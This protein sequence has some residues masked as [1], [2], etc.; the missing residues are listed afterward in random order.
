MI[1]KTSILKIVVLA[2]TALVVIAVVVL[3]FYFA[4][5]PIKE[6][7]HDEHVSNSVPILDRI[8]T[9]PDPTDSKNSDENEQN[10]L[11][12][13]PK[14]Y[15]QI[16][17]IIDNPLRPYVE[18]KV[19]T[20][21]QTFRMLLD[22]GWRYFWVNAAPN[23]VG[24][25]FS[26]FFDKSKSST[27][28]DD[29]IINDGAH[30]VDGFCGKET[31]QLG[32]TVVNNM[33]I[34]FGEEFSATRFPRF[35]GFDGIIG[36]TPGSVFLSEIATLLPSITEKAFCFVPNVYKKVGYHF[37]FDFVVGN[38]GSDKPMISTQCSSLWYCNVANDITVIDEAGNKKKL[39]MSNKSFMFDTGAEVLY[40]ST[41]DFERYKELIG[42]SVDNLKAYEL[43]MEFGDLKFSY[44]TDRH[45]MAV[46]SGAVLFGWVFFRDRFVRWDYESVTISYLKDE[47]FH[48]HLNGAYMQLKSA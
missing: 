32:N 36:L 18:I 15:I 21:P 48:C 31:V 6:K 37:E 35:V 11:S 12:K 33:H 47:D 10:F 14:D 43:Q 45:P 42:G 3:S 19:G 23:L 40:I 27:F 46:G 8:K 22:T 7:K 1:Q 41:T 13:F 16:Q 24:S 25:I 4:A 38:C 26:T 39:M 2:F 29:G 44:H 30:G 5:S 34:C 17:G 28:Q 20:P 9:N